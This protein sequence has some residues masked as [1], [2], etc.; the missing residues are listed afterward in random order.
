MNQTYGNEKYKEHPKKYE[1]SLYDIP[2]FCKHVC[3]SSPLTNNFAL[4]GLVEAPESLSVIEQIA[5]KAVN[6]DVIHDM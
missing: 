5:L 1:G 4:S 3:S 2:S 6:A